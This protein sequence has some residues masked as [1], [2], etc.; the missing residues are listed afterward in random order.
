[1]RGQFYRGALACVNPWKYVFLLGI[2]RLYQNIQ[3]VVPALGRTY[4]GGVP[5]AASTAVGD[6]G[7]PAPVARGNPSAT[8]L[9]EGHTGGTRTID[10]TLRGQTSVSQMVRLLH[11]RRQRRADSLLLISPQIDD[12]IRV[13]QVL[14]LMASHGRVGRSLAERRLAHMPN[15]K[16][17]I[18]R[19]PGRSS[20]AF[21]RPTVLDS[22]GDGL[23]PPA[24]GLIS[25]L[26]DF[27]PDLNDARSTI[28]LD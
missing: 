14:P 3:K 28:S 9:G 21:L 1:M 26:Q 11:S 23:L 8:L 17:S 24:V 7:R 25:V 15:R 2:L 20:I 5:D 6:R 12:T 27:A 10:W 4:L 16:S 13:F 19:S 18:R 22:G